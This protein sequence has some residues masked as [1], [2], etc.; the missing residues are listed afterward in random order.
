MKIFSYGKDGGLKSVVWGLWLIEMKK[1][2]SIALLC[3]ENGSREAFH[4]H[5]FWS[6]SWILS[7][8][9][10]EHQMDGTIRVFK[11]SLIPVIIPRD[12][13]HKVFSFG[14]TWALTFRGPWA[15][16]WKEFIP[17]TGEY[18]TLSSG[19]KIVKVEK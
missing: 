7:G 2:F 6:I 5:A 14:R 1:L 8:R 15:K 12:N 16:T 4:S 17:E 13:F 3:F 11:P 9:L 18:V 10:E 19:R